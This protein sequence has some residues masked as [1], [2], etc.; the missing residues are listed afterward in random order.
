MTTENTQN[1]ADMSDDEL[2]AALA[3][4]FR[5]DDIVE[6]DA[7]DKDA[8]NELN[9]AEA[10]PEADKVPPP[11]PA[12]EASKSAKAPSKKSQ[13]RKNAATKPV[14][15]KD[16]KPKGAKAPA[17]PKVPKAPRVTTQNAKRSAVALDR[18]GANVDGFAL[19]TTDT[20]LKPAEL[21][22][23]RE[24]LLAEIDKLPIKVSEKA[25]NLVAF[26]NGGAKLSCYTEIAIKFLVA[27]GSMTAATLI[28]HLMDQK[29]NGVKGYSKGTANSQG[30]QM[31]KLL[32]LFKI[33][34]VDGK[35]MKVNKSSI[36]VKLV[37]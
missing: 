26:A 7:S 9:V 20:K 4:E 25:I 8:A 13:V 28:A 16:A 12:K 14:S 29:A 30:H 22:T 35:T 31:M 36:I 24:E 11:P 2:E 6:Q 5:E 23:K 3:A 15:S 17:E 33:G 27:E 19:E 1:T 37:K 18:M 34:T 21:K 10:K 32:P